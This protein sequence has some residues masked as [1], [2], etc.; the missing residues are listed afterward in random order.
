MNSIRLDPDLVKKNRVPVLNE[1]PHLLAARKSESSVREIHQF[2]HHP[3]EN[4]IHPE[5]AV[6]SW[7]ACG[8]QLR[9]L[10]QDFLAHSPSE[11]EVIST[12]NGSIPP[13]PD[14]SR[15]GRY[16]SLNKIGPC[17]EC[18]TDFAQGIKKNNLPLSAGLLAVFKIKEAHVPVRLRSSRELRI[19]IDHALED[20]SRGICSRGPH[21]L[22]LPETGLNSRPPA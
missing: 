11:T 1:L 18:G 16:V 12:T 2:L 14:T 19:F 6:S 7:P 4:G 9:N 20:S 21:R 17:I 13:L 3:L 5:G 22:N 8:T 10:V 15:S